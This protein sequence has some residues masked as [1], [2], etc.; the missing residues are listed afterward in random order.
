MNPPQSTD[1]NI[2]EAVWDH[3]DRGRNKRQPTSKEELWDVLQEA[4]R[5]IPEDYF[6]KWQQS[7]SKTDEAVTVWNVKSVQEIEEHGQDNNV[8]DDCARS[9]GLMSEWKHV[10]LPS[11][12]L[13]F[14]SASGLSSPSVSPCSAFENEKKTLFFVTFVLSSWK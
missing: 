5:T 1:L 4:W 14:S 2:T 10:L 3:V 13:T 11:A 9:V 8:P 7:L 6:K 12:G